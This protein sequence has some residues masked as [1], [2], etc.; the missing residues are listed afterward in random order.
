M[1]AEL[2]AQKSDLEGV[3][4]V[5][6]MEKYRRFEISLVL[7]LERGKLLFCGLQEN[8]PRVK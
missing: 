8:A 2:A 7:D 6:N 5:N 4:E 1:G 3:D